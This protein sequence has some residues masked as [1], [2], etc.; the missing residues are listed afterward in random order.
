M[1]VNLRLRAACLRNASTVFECPIVKMNSL[2][3]CVLGSS[4]HRALRTRG[5][6]RERE[7]GKEDAPR[8]D[9][10]GRLLADAAVRHLDL[11]HELL[12]RLD[13]DRL[14]VETALRELVLARERRRAAVAEARARVGR[15]ERVRALQDLRRRGRLALDGRRRRRRRRRRRGRREPKAGRARRERARRPSGGGRRGLVAEEVEEAAE[16]GARRARAEVV[17]AV[18]RAAAEVAVEGGGFG[19]DGRRVRAR[20]R[21]G[22]LVEVVGERRL[23]LLA[24]EHADAPRHARHNEFCGRASGFKHVSDERT[25]ERRGRG[26]GTH[27]WAQ[28]PAAP[29]RPRPSA[30]RAA[31]TS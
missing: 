23:V 1:T 4:Q 10:V 7:R 24:D 11:V 29:C 13:E 14:E 26:R 25:E 27:L 20:G 21:R 2:R 6:R 18:V 31:R 9:V 19:R 28:P 17:L 5:T 3:A 30:R 15:Q 16:C 22:R 12:D 8:V